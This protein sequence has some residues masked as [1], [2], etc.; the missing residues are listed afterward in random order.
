MT[1]TL[2]FFGVDGL[3]AW[4]KIVLTRY[5]LTY[6]SYSFDRLTFYMG[7]HLFIYS[8]MAYFILAP[9]TA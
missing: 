7:V 8:L 2:I 4:K 1:P 9:S 6:T 5:T 3:K